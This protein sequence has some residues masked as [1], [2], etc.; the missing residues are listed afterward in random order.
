MCNKCIIVLAL[1]LII[2]IVIWFTMSKK[3]IL[4]TKTQA[5][6]NPNNAPQ[7]AKGTIVNCVNGQWVIEPN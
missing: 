4:S 3:P 1:L 2:G 5:Q 6:C 7:V